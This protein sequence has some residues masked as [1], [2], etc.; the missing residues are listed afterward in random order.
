MQYIKKQNTEPAGWKGWF[1]TA[2]NHRTYDY[3][4]DYGALVNLSSAKQ[5]LLTEQNG[6]CAYCQQKLKLQQASIEHVIPKEY[7]LEL[8]TSY[9][10][11]VAV[12]KETPKDWYGND[13]CDKHKQ[14]KM[15]APL[16]FA[17]ASNVTELFNHRYFT[18]NFD[19]SIHVKASATDED[20]KLASVF[21]DVLNLNHNLLKDKRKREAIDPL[22]DAMNSLDAGE[23]RNFLKHQFQKILLNKERPFRM[24]LLIYIAGKIGIS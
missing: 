19:G 20:K 6:L 3:G 15:I 13:H 1:T 22:F 2:T 17:S 4:R 23:K 9:F 11:L 10:N 5:F 18:A 14:S 24:F 12:C 16:I 7:N 21:I 8:S